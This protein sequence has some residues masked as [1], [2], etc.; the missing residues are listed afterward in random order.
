MISHWL[1]LGWICGVV[2]KRSFLLKE[3]DG[4][5]KKDS[6][7]HFLCPPL[8]LARWEK[9]IRKPPWISY[10]VL[11]LSKWSL[12]PGLIAD[13]SPLL[14]VVTHGHFSLFLILFPLFFLASFMPSSSVP[15]PFLFLSDSSKSFEF[16]LNWSLPALKN[17]SLECYSTCVLLFFNNKLTWYT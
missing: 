8:K 6:L 14:L 3:R 16:T 7:R 12:C 17:V 10:S 11:F 13:V 5:M 1:V 2:S 15:F 9:E 4:R